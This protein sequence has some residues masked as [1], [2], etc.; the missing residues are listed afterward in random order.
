MKNA[1]MILGLAAMAAATTGFGAVTLGGTAD[2]AAADTMAPVTVEGHLVKFTSMSDFT[3][4]TMKETLTVDTT[5]MTHVTE[6][7]MAM[8]IHSLKPGWLL[9]V[10][11]RKTPRRSTPRASPSTR[12]ELLSNLAQ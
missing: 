9:T 7:G 6:S 11:A 10:K 3:L 4:N 1:R 2:A 5:S 12:C 8:K